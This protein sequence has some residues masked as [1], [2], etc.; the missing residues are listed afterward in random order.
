MKKETNSR[1][2]GGGQRKA[3]RN[4]TKRRRKRRN[5]EAIKTNWPAGRFLS[6]G[7]PSI[8][9]VASGRPVQS[10][11]LGN[12]PTSVFPGKLHSVIIKDKRH[13]LLTVSLCKASNK[14]RNHSD[15]ACVWLL[16]FDT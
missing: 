6:L 10:N 12:S 4:R 11:F 8:I 14:L 2:G 3:R 15:R 16:L 13:R 1:R 7:F 5:K 9:K